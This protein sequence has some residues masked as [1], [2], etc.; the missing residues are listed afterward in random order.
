MENRISSR[1][2]DISLEK[3]KLWQPFWSPSILG[4][5]HF[6]HQNPDRCFGGPLISDSSFGS[7]DLFQWWTKP[8]DGGLENVPSL[9]LT[10]RPPGEKEHHLQKCLGRGYVSSQDGTYMKIGRI[11]KEGLHLPTIDFQ[12]FCCYIVLWEGIS[13][14]KAPGKSQHISPLQK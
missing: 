5:H 7:S 11:P 1:F 3:K 8:I 13:G 4:F 12:S 6:P 2:Q 10:A 14:F 9:K